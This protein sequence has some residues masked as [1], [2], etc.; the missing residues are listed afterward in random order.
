LW[1]DRRVAWALERA[2]NPAV[3][4]LHT[5]A[6]LTRKTIKTCPPASAPPPLRWLLGIPDV[7]SVDL[8]RY[9]ARLNLTSDTNLGLLEEAAGR[10]LEGSWGPPVALP[11]DE[12]PRRFPVGHSGGRRAAESL[13]MAGRQPVLLALFLVSGVA[14]ATLD[15][16]EVRVRLGRLFEW[17]EVEGPVRVALAPFSPFLSRRFHPEGPE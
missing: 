14:E 7:R 9:R 15:E 8:H 16:G 11:P 4:R 2:A 12:A 17:E 6:E 1:Q 5:T 13:E 3:L 10:A